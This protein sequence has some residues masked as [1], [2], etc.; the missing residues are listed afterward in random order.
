MRWKQIK[1]SEKRAHKLVASLVCPLWFIDFSAQKYANSLTQS[2][3]LLLPVTCFIPGDD[4]NDITDALL[5]LLTNAN[6]VS[7]NEIHPKLAI[8]SI[9]LVVCFIYA[10]IYI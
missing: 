3:L 10:Y 1:L 5:I 9:H 6:C 7:A 2:L 8:S 4:D